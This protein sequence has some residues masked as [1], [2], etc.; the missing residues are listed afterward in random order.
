[1]E[2]LKALKLYCLFNRSKDKKRNLRE[3]TFSYKD[4]SEL[5]QLLK[6]SKRDREKIA[7]LRGITWKI[8]KNK[9]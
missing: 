5:K 1:M 4:V 3:D 7:E 8:L 9:T 6:L 2:A